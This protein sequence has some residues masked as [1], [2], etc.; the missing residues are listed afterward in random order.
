MSR[1]SKVVKVKECLRLEQMGGISYRMIGKSIGCSHN[2]V[3]KILVRATEK[4]ITWDQ[5]QGMDEQELEILLYGERPSTLAKRPEP[6]MV[7]MDQELRKTGVNLTLLWHEYKLANPDGLQ[8]TQF[9]DHYRKWAGIK[10]V[11]LHIQH[12]AGEKM[13]VD[14]MG[15]TMS[16]ID[17]DT[18]EMITAYLFVSTVGTSSYPYVEAF[19]TKEKENWIT[20]H[21][22]AFSYYGRLPLILVPDNDKSAVTGYI[23]YDPILNKTYYEMAE[24]YGVAVIP[25]R[26]QR[27]KD[28]AAVE[29]GVG[30]SETWIMAALRHHT[31]FSFLELNQAIRRKLVEF[32][33][34]PF[35]KQEGSRHSNYFQ[36]DVPVM[37]SLPQH[38]YSYGE[39]KVATV[40]TDYHIEAR[41]Q[42]YSVPYL[43]VGQT[44]DVRISDHLVEIFQHGTRIGSHPR[45][46][47]KERQYA[48]LLAHMP[49]NHQYYVGMNKESLLAWAQTIGTYTEELVSH[50]FARVR[51]EQ[52]GY[53]SCMGLKRLVKSYGSS[54]T[55][56]ACGKAIQIQAYG[57][58]YVE[59]FIK[60]SLGNHPYPPR[61]K[62]TSLRTHENLRGAT[63]YGGKEEETNA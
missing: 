47:G 60:V 50:I 9:C 44:V 53:R 37:R 62:D 46:L 40:N 27:A 51:V 3:K 1:R 18:G 58:S 17:P 33:N 20:A 35:Q 41:K 48:T 49:T 63:Y 11:T 25:A 56:E 23:K 55:E 28:K 14:W 10:S 57:C 13:F 19:P 38:P 22:H 34:R 15:P 5:A 4:N 36:Y 59:K 6:D 8:Y 29:K 32:S 12:K 2:T 24:H 45:L 7:T 30:D 26:R 42:Y 16:V 21:L 54:L 52:Q 43:Y 31:F 39:W 61:K